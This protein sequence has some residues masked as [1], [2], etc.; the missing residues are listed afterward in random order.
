MR[1]DQQRRC[2]RLNFIVGAMCSLLSLILKALLS[3]VTHIHRRCALLA[4]FT[5]AALFVL[6]YSRRP[7]QL[8]DAGLAARCLSTCGRKEA[9][10]GQLMKINIALSLHAPS[11][12]ARAKQTTAATVTITINTTTYS[13]SDV[14]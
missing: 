1:L 5:F 10:P 7:N 11:A 2:Y 3:L 12:H 14:M 13:T 8:V 4:L 9:Q 6:S